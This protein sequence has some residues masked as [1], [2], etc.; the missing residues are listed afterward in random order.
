MF[1]NHSQCGVWNAEPYIIAGPG[2]KKSKPQKE[3][4]P[5]PSAK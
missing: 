4:Q 1:R 3:K 2:K 5:P